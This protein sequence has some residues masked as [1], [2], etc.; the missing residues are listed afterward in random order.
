MAYIAARP[1]RFDRDYKIGERIPPEAIDP[2]RARNL[3][4]MG[5]IIGVGLPEPEGQE[6]TDGEGDR[7]SVV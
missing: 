5:K 6:P 1:V 2:A 7:K 3:V 4:E